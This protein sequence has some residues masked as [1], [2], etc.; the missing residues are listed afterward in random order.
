M[1]FEQEVNFELLSIMNIYQFQFSW[2]VL[3]SWKMKLVYILK[4]DLCLGAP[5]S[6]DIFLGGAQRVCT[7]RMSVHSFGA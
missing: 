2:H 4:Q 5:Q 7:T 6:Q 3:R 1:H